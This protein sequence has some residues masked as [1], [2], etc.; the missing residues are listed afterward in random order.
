MPTAVLAGAFGQRNPGDDALLRA[1]ARALDGWHLVAT[2]APG[3][4]AEALAGC[5]PVPAD[6]PPAT[7]RAVARA[8]AVV[9]AGGTIFKVLAPSCG[10]R[11]ASLLRRALALTAGPRALGRPVLMVGFGACA[12][13]TRPARALARTLVGRADLLVLRD[14]ESAAVLEATGA[15]APF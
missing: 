14:E 10:R 9:L 7:A 1:F 8:D 5:E 6:D 11:P 12:L 13:P 15:P 4:P 2:A 3:P